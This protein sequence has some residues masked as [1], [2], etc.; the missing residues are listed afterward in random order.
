MKSHRERGVLGAKSFWHKYKTDKNFREILIKKWS[1]SRIKNYEKTNKYKSG[2]STN[3]ENILKSILCGF[4][5]ADGSVFIRTEKKTGK[6]HYEIRF[7]P[8]DYKL[9]ELFATS[10]EKL[11]GKIV[12]VKQDNKY[13]RISICNKVATNDLLSL[14]DFSSK[15][16]TFPKKIIKSKE[17]KKEW[18]RSYFDCDGY[19]GKKYVQLQSVNMKG[20]KKNSRTS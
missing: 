20:L 12:H 13:Y 5:A 17:C 4:L 18:L 15:N 16:W 19:V 1:A 10:F 14:A 11:Y 2:I 8:D 6:V 9:V 7:Y 3:D